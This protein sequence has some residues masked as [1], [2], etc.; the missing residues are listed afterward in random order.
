[1]GKPEDVALVF[2]DKTLFGAIRDCITAHRRFVST[3]SDVEMIPR[4]I[5]AK[6]DNLFTGYAL[7]YLM[8]GE[9]ARDVDRAATVLSQLIGNESVLPAGRVAIGDWL[10]SD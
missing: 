10:A 7:T 5:V 4:L 1:M 3:P 6:R 8:E 2:S 9:A